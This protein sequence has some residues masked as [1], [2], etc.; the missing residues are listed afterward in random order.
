MARWSAH[1]F[2]VP[3]PLGRVGTFTRYAPFAVPLFG[4]V[5]CVNALWTSRQQI[6]EVL[7][8]DTATTASGRG[9]ETG[10]SRFQ[11]IWWYGK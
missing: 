2:G 9:G 6:T 10:S 5:I 1:K 11:G 7:N 8:D 3:A 4:V